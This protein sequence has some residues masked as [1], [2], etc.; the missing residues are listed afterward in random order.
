MKVLQINSVCGLRSTGR[1]CTDI[2]DVLKEMGHDCLIAYGREAVP[3]KYKSITIKTDSRL[4]TELHAL[5]S[6]FLDNS[7][8]ARRRA[9]KK[10][11][12]EIEQYNPDIIHLHNIHGYFLNIPELFAYL[13]RANKPIVW[14]LHDCWT[15][16]GHCTH[17]ERTDCNKWETEC[18]DCPQKKRYPK[19][20]FIDA[21]RKN[22]LQKK[23]L[24]NGINNLVLVTPSE[25]LAG[26]VRRSF[27]SEYPISVIHNGIDAKVFSYTESDFRKKYGLED[28]KIV[29]GVASSWGR[30]KGFDDFILL[31]QRLKESYC[32]VIVG[33]TEEEKR[34]LPSNVIA[35][36]RTNS[37]KELA[38][39][40]S[41]ADVFANLTYADNY[42]TVN[43][44]A[45]CCGTPA[46]TYNTGGSIE[47]VPS[48]Q[49]VEQKDLDHLID[50]I[51][52]ICENKTGK[53]FN[54]EEFS[55]Q[56][57]FDKYI[58]LYETL[59]SQKE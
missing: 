9:T 18:F 52:E 4:G 14:T 42:P 25:W 29:L 59:L 39:I 43:L 13:H 19:S 47:S 50:L 31:S 53:L 49:I 15:F 55:R 16:T 28:K 2:A 44:E 41:A 34:L 54:T 22:Y 35:I 10:F 21:S 40:Y 26:Y 3:A 20:S 58:K 48:E 57:S 17:P 45:Q 32:V 1:I 7:G 12:R 24:F 36:E 6:R 38:E 37:A 33:V 11:I 46:I 5:Q 8:F 23:S 27:L 56:Y 51:Y 30:T